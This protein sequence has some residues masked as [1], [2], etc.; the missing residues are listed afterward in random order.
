MRPLAGA[1]RPGGKN[2][3]VVMVRAML[4][5]DIPAATDVWQVAYSA[6]SREYR[7]EVPARSDAT[8]RRL[9]SRLAHFLA[10]DPTGS[11]VAEADGRVVGL[12]QAFVREG[13]WVLSLLATLPG[14]Q[15]HGLG[16]RLLE[17]ALVFGNPGSPGTIQAS[18]DPA[19]VALYCSAGFACHPAMR[20]EGRITRAVGA[21]RRVRAGSGQDLG[22]VDAIDRARRGAARGVD[23]EHL[24][25]DP[26]NHLLVMEDRGYAVARDD[27]LITLGASDEEAAVA[28]LETVLATIPVGERFEA[29]WLTSSQQW[30]IETLVRSGIELHPY[31]AVMVRAMPGPPTP[32]IPSGGYG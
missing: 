5:D 19:A 4:A 7:L 31:G 29:A 13:Y 15:G 25:A 12:A 22:Q 8:D 21:D 2:R 11:F 23:V 17:A 10:T 30:A 27:R 20:A 32:Y 18:R 14:H 9:E 26:G 3:T 28:L 16:R 6:M 24:L 1:L